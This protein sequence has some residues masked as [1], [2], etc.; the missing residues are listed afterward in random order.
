VYFAIIA[1]AI[2]LG[3]WNQPATEFTARLVDGDFL[4][5]NT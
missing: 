5:F 2:L 4:Q 1:A 3:E